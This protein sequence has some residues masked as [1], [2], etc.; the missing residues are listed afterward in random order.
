MRERQRAQK[1]AV[2]QTENGC[3]R[4]N[5]QGK[6]HHHSEGESGTT[7]KIAQSK[8]EILKERREHGA[9]ITG[10]RLANKYFAQF[11]GA[12]T[13]EV[14]LTVETEP[15]SISAQWA[16]RLNSSAKPSRTTASSK[17]LV[18]EGWA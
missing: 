8:F 16:T 1:N 17:D 14:W 11:L 18:A 6:R 12:F 4:T 2:H 5:A 9:I 15:P 3:R 13:F 10:G 7:A